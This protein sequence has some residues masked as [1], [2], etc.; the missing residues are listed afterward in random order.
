M[1]RRASLAYRRIEDMPLDNGHYRMGQPQ[2][3]R[4]GGQSEST[5]VG[6]AVSKHNKVSISTSITRSETNS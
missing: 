3:G 6:K 2:I 1:L 4:T 5:A